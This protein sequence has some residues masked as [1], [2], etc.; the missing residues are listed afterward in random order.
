M[1]VMMD[2]RRSKRLAL[3]VPVV[4]YG[5]LRDKSNLHEKTRTLSVSAHGGMLSLAAPVQSGQ[6]ILLV[7]E[8][9][10]EEQECRVVYVGSRKRGKA[11]VGLA[12]TRPV[13]DFW[14][15]SFPPVGRHSLSP[16]SR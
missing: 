8:A 4:V 9:T 15:V 7:N 3:S 5:Q 6:A 10:R 2:R 16:S 1:M 14:Q 11:E 12:F 13:S